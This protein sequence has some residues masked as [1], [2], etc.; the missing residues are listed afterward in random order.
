[1]KKIMFFVLLF[2]S[3]GIKAQDM[4]FYIVGKDDN[5]KNIELNTQ[6]QFD[7]FHFLS[8]TLRMQDMLYAMVVPG[9]V[10]FG[11]G[12]KK[13]AYTMLAM[14]TAGYAALGYSAY[15]VSKYLTIKDVFNFSKVSQTPELEQ[16]SKLYSTVA[17][18]G[19]VLIFGTYFFDWIHGRKILIHKQEIIRYKYAVKL[20]LSSDIV[21]VNNKI[22]PTVGLNLSF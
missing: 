15:N 20:N 3:F 21:N 16:N 13:T 1:M 14:R 18:T 9:Y 4:D 22:Y 12:K 2:I 6:M 5:F 11:V 7:E 19:A 10:H 17:I 8:K